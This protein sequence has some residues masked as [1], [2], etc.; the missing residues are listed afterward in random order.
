M[1]NNQSFTKNTSQDIIE[2]VLRFGPSII[3][4][5][6]VIVDDCIE[7]YSSRCLEE[8]L[9][10]PIPVSNQEIKWFLPKEYL[11]F[12]IESWLLSKCENSLT[13]DRVQL[14]LTI[15]KQ[16]GLLVILK[17]M[18]YIVDT[19]RSQN[20]TW[21]VGR[22]SSVASYCLYLIGVHKVDSLKYNLDVRDFFK[23]I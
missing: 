23:E 12:D 17:L 7:K 11:D 9:N 6:D 5:C 15:Y 20:L 21:G 22:G 14:E 10:Y 16:K 18:K 1:S 3:S 13:S 19:L 4:Y 2:G 8:K